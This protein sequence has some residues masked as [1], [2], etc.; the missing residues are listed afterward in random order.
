MLL[1]VTIS[2]DW[3]VIKF[4][5]HFVT[6]VT[7]VSRVYFLNCATSNLNI[8]LTSYKLFCIVQHCPKFW[9]QVS[10]RIPGRNWKMKHEIFYF[11]S[12][13]LFHFQKKKR[14]DMTFLN[15]GTSFKFSKYWKKKLS[16]PNAWNPDALTY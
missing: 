10:S 12:I 2:V 14:G 6:F 11:T 16:Q 4:D 7:L 13:S 1:S 8:F 5:H 9:T 3:N 15:Q